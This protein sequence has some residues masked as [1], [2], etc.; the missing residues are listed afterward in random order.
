MMYSTS[1]CHSG[2]LWDPWW[3]GARARGRGRVR[4]C[5][6]VCVCVCMYVCM[7]VGTFPQLGQLFLIP[8]RVNKFTEPTALP[9]A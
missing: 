9:H 2:K 5:V 6:C 1:Y 7:Y 4:V 8:N 3:V